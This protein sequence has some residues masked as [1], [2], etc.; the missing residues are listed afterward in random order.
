MKK[1]ILFGA[2]MAVS[3]MTAGLTSCN[4]GGECKLKTSQD[5]LSY[6]EGIIF[7]NMYINQL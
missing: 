4:K 6:A 3:I 1:R 7:A 2:V 5:S